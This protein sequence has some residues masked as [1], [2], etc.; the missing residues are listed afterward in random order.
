MKF[1]FFNIYDPDPGGGTPDP[2]RN[3][4]KFRKFPGTRFP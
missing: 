2:D 3:F 1:I 4:G